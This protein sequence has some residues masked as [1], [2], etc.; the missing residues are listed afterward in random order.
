MSAK[1]PDDS[2]ELRAGRRAHGRLRVRFP[3]KLVSIHGTQ[4]VEVQNLSQAG[5]KLGWNK[6]L[7]AGVDVMVSWGDF[8]LYGRVIWTRDD[9]AGIALD[10]ALGEAVLLSMRESE[11]PPP[12]PAP[13]ANEDALFALRNYRRTGGRY[14][15]N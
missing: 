14:W 1:L 8:E 9:S 15:W 5:L 10:Q 2:L 12:P 11:A 4:Q 7:P 13:P 3:A 6:A